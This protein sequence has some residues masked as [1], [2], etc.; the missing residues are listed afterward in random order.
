MPNQQFRRM[1]TVEETAGL[2]GIGRST[3]YELILRNELTATRIGKRWLISPSTLTTILGET[4]PLPAHLEGPN[5]QPTLPEVRKGGLQNRTISSDPV[6][7]VP[8]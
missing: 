1:Y 8:I 4:P 3:A 7:A 6:G 2:L 5:H